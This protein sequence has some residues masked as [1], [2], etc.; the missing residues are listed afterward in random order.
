MS[1]IKTDIHTLSRDG[2]IAW[3]SQ[4]DI[5][6][7]RAEQIRRWIYSAQVDSFDDMTNIKNDIRELLSE[8]F[9]IPRLSVVTT[10]NSRDGCCKFLFGRGWC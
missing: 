7:F 8:H 9:T 5:A 4:R 6:S 2:L 1:L 10:E 3:L